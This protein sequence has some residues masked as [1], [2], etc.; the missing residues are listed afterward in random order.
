MN[1]LR[2][3]LLVG[4]LGAAMTAGS[5]AQARVVLSDNFDGEG[6]GSMLQYTGFANWNVTGVGVD[7]VNSGDYG[8]TCAGGAGKCVDLDGTPGPGGI[9]SKDPFAVRDGQLVTLS[10]DYSGNQRRNETDSFEGG[11]LFTP[12]LGLNDVTLIKG[13]VTRYV[14]NISPQDFISFYNPA[15]AQDFP[16]THIELSGRISGTGSLKLFFA[17]ESG[18]NVGPL[19]DNVSL[20]L[21]NVPEP[22]TWAMMLMGFGGM[23]AVLRRRRTLALA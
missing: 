7:L 8:I 13:G 11:F 21:G 9:I 16:W 6:S 10:F 23:G 18:D 12:L 2:L 17:A 20:S 14:G 3:G 1:R 4:A 22:A 15:A 19:L 5:A